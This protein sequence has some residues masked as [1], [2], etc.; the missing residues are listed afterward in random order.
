MYNGLL[1]AHSGLRWILLLA[2]VLATIIALIK[3]LTSSDKVKILK[4]FSL[5]TLISAHLQLLIGIALYFMTPRFQFSSEAMKD[6]V[7]RF[8]MVEHSLMM[9]IAIILI[10]VGHSIAK[11]KIGKAKA[12]SLSIFFG[13]SLL[14][15]LYM[16]PWPGQGFGVGYF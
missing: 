3:W 13:I 10:T 5:I 16:I 7:Q 4:P 9:V 12:K 14:I 2:L 1:H 11:K 8:F 15:V 6:T